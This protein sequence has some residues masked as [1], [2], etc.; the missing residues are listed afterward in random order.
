[1]AARW[2]V[3]FIS[4]PCALRAPCSPLGVAAVADACDIFCLL[5]GQAPFLFL[6]TIALDLV[7]WD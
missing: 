4:F 3:V 1:M 6:S 2:Q 7:S 5:I